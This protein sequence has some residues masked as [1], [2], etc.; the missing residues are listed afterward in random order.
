VIQSFPQAVRSFQSGLLIPESAGLI[1]TAQRKLLPTGGLFILGPSAH[2]KWQDLVGVD[3][4][5]IHIVMDR[6]RANASNLILE[7]AERYVG[8]IALVGT[9][10]EIQILRLFL[11]NTLTP[12]DLME[13]RN[14]VS[15]LAC[16]AFLA[17]PPLAPS[18]GYA[19]PKWESVNPAAEWALAGVLAGMAFDQGRSPAIHG[20]LKHL[21]REWSFGKM[22]ENR[23]EDGLVR[24]RPGKKV[25]AAKAQFSTRRDVKIFKL[26]REGL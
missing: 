25:E 16:G 18:E 14:P 21:R 5:Q 15:R 1:A 22:G 2:P 9:N 11:E 24:K 12:Q 26:L 17:T 13:I 7:A 3:E 20:Y 19:D 23:I 8:P 4:E 10:D 6:A